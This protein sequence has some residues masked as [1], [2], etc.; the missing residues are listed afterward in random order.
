VVKQSTHRPKIEGLNPAKDKG[1]DKKS[2]ITFADLTQ[3]QIT[4]IFN[5]NFPIYQVKNGIKSTFF[6]FGFIWI[7][8]HQFCIFSCFNNIPSFISTLKRR[9]LVKL[10]KPN[11][12]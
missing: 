4:N 10:A 9:P 1:K 6:S 7:R 5:Q 11:Y 2:K 3:R 8:F 12:N